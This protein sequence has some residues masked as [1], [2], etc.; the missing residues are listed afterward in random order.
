[1]DCYISTYGLPALFSASEAEIPSGLLPVRIAEDAA[2]RDRLAK[3][4][5]IKVGI[6]WAGSPAY[7]EDRYRSMR[8]ESF[9]PLAEI[10]GLSLV[11]LQIGSPADEI[12]SGRHGLKILHAPQ[13]LSPL[14]KTA[15]LMRELDLVISVDTVIAHLAGALGVE[16]W[17]LLP[18]VS[19]WVW[20]VHRPNDTPWYPTHRLF[21][22]QRM[23]DWTPVIE[24]VCVELRSRIAGR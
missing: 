21:R 20:N 6:C 14:T 15:A 2:W 24:R 3:I 8:L 18:Y 23:N 10:R 9:A 13:E 11:S 19:H 7:Q 4:G 12:L 1:V 5:G 17:L 16:T 22:Q